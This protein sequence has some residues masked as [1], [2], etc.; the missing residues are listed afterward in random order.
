MCF[1]IITY[2]WP[3]SICWLLSL[4]LL[5]GYL[6][7]GELAWAKQDLMRQP[8]PT[9]ARAL[10]LCARA[11]SSEAGGWSKEASFRGLLQEQLLLALWLF[12]LF[13]SPA[14]GDRCPMFPSCSQYAVEAIS[15]YGAFWGVILTSERLL[16]CGRES[17][18]PLVQ[19]QG[20]YRFFDPLEGNV[21]WHSR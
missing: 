21:L 8:W 2:F 9:K 20:E 1:K 11:V 17:S 13:I 15:R 18:Y 6:L 12:Q 3:K 10:R 7:R 14:D 4:M 16:R 19:N 5:T